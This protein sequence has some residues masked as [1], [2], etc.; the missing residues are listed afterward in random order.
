MYG[1]RVVIFSIDGKQKSTIQLQKCP[2]GIAVEPIH[3]RFVVIETYDPKVKV[4]NSDNSLAYEF[5]TVPADEVGKPHS[6]RTRGVAVK[7]DGTI[8]VTY[9]QGWVYTEHKPSN[10][11]LL[12]TVPVKLCPAQL[13]VDNKDRVIISNYGARPFV[14]VTDGNSYTLFTIEPT[15]LGKPAKYCLDVYAD[16]S[17]IY[18]TMLGPRYKGHIHHYDLDGRFLDCLVRGLHNP[19]GITFTPDG[20]LA[21][22]DEVSVKMFHKV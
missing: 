3:N 12:R 17:G 7:K 8:L 22:A 15:I 9:D 11:E 18:V 16:S 13:A 5:P 10:G 4:F 19:L 20:Q 14:A 6:P 1:N 2:R 21:V